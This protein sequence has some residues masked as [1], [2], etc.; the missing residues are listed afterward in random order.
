MS[1]D[2]LAQ[3]QIQLR[4]NRSRTNST[5]G[6]NFRISRIPCL[7]MNLRSAACR[8]YRWNSRY[9]NP[10]TTSQFRTAV[11]QCRQFLCSSLSLS[12][13]AQE[14]LTRNAHTRKSQN[15]SAQPIT[16]RFS[17]TMPGW[18]QS[19]SRQ[20]TTP[21]NLRDFKILQSPRLQHNPIQPKTTRR[22]C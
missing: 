4:E 16:R 5:W 13:S 19:L 18:N 20:F 12:L 17:S 7:E 3:G 14:A 21:H 6:L 8:I 15:S 2:F 9:S 22:N 1:A 11:L 10:P